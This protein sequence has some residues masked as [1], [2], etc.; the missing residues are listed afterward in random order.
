[1]TIYVDSARH[2]FRGHMMCHMTADSLGELHDMA[3]QIEMRR[4]WFQIPP[5]ASFPHYDIPAPRR[6]LAISY[7]AVEVTA[8]TSLYFAA[9]LGLEWAEFHGDEVLLTRY[10]RTLKRAAV[11]VPPALIRADLPS[12][13]HL[14]I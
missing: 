1:M 14:A 2:P 5:K 6:A 10:Y 11:H 7:G 13:S 9:R 8:R 3:A 12:F 4:E